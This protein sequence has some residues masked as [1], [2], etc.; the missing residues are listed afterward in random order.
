[1]L[2]LF[3]IRDGVPTALL[4]QGSYRFDLLALSVLVAVLSSIMALQVAGM[5]RLA[6]STLLRQTAFLTGS[7]SLGVGIWSMHFIGMLAFNLCTTVSYD[8]RLTLLSML[9]A[10][11]AS[12]V[13]LNLLWHRQINTVQLVSGGVLVGS[14]IGTMH[15]SGMAAMVMAPQLR[16]DPLWFA[17]STCAGAAPSAP[18]SPLC[19]AGW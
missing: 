11:F 13:T 10:I 9:P 14:G 5:A 16:Y 6:H 12:W 18:C 2:D 3:F 1:M 17:A 15:Y 7:F 4:L 19:W 8:Y